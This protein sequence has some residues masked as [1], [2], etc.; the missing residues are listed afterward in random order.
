MLMRKTTLIATGVAATLII[1]CRPK[2]KTES[3]V[4]YAVGDWWSDPGSNLLSAVKSGQPVVVCLSSEG[5][6]P[7]T[8]LSA[9]VPRFEKTVRRALQEWFKALQV[10]VQI[11]TKQAPCVNDLESGHVQ[12]VLHYNEPLFQ[13]RVAQTTSPTL[14]VFLIGD[15]GLHLNVNG[16]LNPARDATEGFKTT[17]HELGHAMG[18]NHSNVKGAVMLPYL[19]QA[20]SNL[21]SD[22]IQGIQQVWKR[23]PETRYPAPV[24]KDSSDA[25]DSSVSK[26]TTTTNSAPTIEPRA[27]QQPIRTQSSVYVVLRYDSWFKASTAQSFALP[28]AEKCQLKLAQKLAVQILDSGNL[29]ARH[30]RVK[31]VDGIPNCRLGSAGATG[32]LYKDHLD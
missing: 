3:E 2:Q 6:P 24:R 19:S 26:V 25:S 13:S 22:D 20:S 16:V 4:T 27:T 23:L 9:D 30:L 8:R 28:E 29:Q 31:L 5:S 18:L 32:F 15:G 21:T 7:A 1:G 12:V 11:Q 17:L 10:N 14:G